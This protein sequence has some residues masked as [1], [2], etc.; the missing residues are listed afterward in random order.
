MD[1]YQTLEVVT[2][3]DRES[4]VALLLTNWEKQ[5]TSLSALFSARNKS[6]VAELMCASIHQFLI[7]L[8]I[9][10][11]KDFTS[12][13]NLIEEANS[14]EYKPINFTERF[15]FIKNNPKLHHSFVQLC[16]LYNEQIKLYAKS[17]IIRSKQKK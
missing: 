17:K 14:L 2:D 7:L 8:S 1:N 3:D 9:T 16:E 6:A 4:A 13:E 10:N 15:E 5:K 11:L 12:E